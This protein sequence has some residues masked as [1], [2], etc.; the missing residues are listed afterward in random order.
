LR[1]YLA[2]RY[3]AD[4]ITKN[5]IESIILSLRAVSGTVYE[6]NK[7][8][9]K[10]IADGFILNRDDRTQKDFFVE[11]ID[12]AAPENNIFKVVNQVEIQGYEFRIPDAIVYING[13]PLVVL[14]FK[15]AV[16]ENTTILNA[17]EQLTIRYKRDIPELFKYNAFVVISD[18]ANNKYGSLFAPYDFFYAWR[19]IGETRAGLADDTEV[20]GIPSLVS[21][22]K[23]LF[24]KDRLLQVVKNYVYFPDNAEGELKVVCRYPQFFAA[25]KLFRNINAHLRPE[26]D[27]KGGTYFGATGCGKSYTMLFLTR[28]LM[29]S[30]YFHSPTI[31]VIT[32]R[33]DLDDQLSKQFVSSKDYIDDNTVISIDSREQLRQ[34][35]QGRT[36]SGVYLTTIQKFTEDTQLLTD[37]ANVIC[38]SD[39]AHRSQV[40]LDQKVRVRAR[41]WNVLTASRNIFTTA[42]RTRPMW[43]LPE[44]RLT[45][46]L[47][48]SA[49]SWTATR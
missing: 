26:G 2:D 33:T 1:L 27:G 6:A 17:Y 24:R 19:K 39:E 29:K 46:R 40:N 21:M 7:T 36:S 43:D 11:L 25:E 42:C 3:A 4:G 34:E 47:K 15:S 37:R 14:E 22:I 18:G 16:K 30:P 5:E 20:D 8:V 35:L 9:F 45:Q 41:V 10:M 48:C 28:L 49:R 12:F 23:G 13:L 32:D 31:L 38:I 44:R